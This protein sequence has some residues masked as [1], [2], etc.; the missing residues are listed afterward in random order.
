[1]LRKTGCEADV[2]AKKFDVLQALEHQ[3]Y[4]VILI[5]VQMPKLDRIEAAKRI[6]GQWHDKPRTI[7][8]AAY[9]LEG[10]MVRDLNA[11]MNDYISKPIHAD[12]ISKPLP[13]ARHFSK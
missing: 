11:E 10:N 6:P 2:V 12:I 3:P 7:A 5:D 4:D 9:A 13:I 1:M 8:L